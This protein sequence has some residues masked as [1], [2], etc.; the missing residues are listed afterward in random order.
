MDDRHGVSAKVIMKMI[1][2]ALANGWEIPEDVTTQVPEYLLSVVNDTEESTRNRINAASALAKIKEQRTESL[3]KAAK[4][5]IDFSVGGMSGAL[6]DLPPEDGEPMVDDT[7]KG[8]IEN[9][10]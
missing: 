10:H 2:E 7:P 8:S 1:E 5:A 9:G 3:S 6:A 4:W